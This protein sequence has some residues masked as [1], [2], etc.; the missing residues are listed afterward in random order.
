MFSIRLI[1]SS[2]DK[3]FS[4]EN[5]KKKK[6]IR[7][8]SILLDKMQCSQ[9]FKCFILNQLHVHFKAWKITPIFAINKLSIGFISSDPH[10][11][12]F[13]HF[14]VSMRW[15]HNKPR[16]TPNCMRLLD[17]FARFQWWN[18]Y[19]PLIMLSSWRNKFHHKEQ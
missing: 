6:K 12:I 8:R 17:H 11:L 1:I 18:I 5:T 14:N 9:C 3:L 2:W 16:S 15:W 7:N 13:L 4:V 19:L 10:L